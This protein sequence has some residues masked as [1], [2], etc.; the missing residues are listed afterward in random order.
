MQLANPKHSAA[1][2]LI[3][4]ASAFAQQDATRQT[5]QLRTDQ[6]LSGSISRDTVAR[7]APYPLN[8]RYQ[9][10]TPQEKA[11]LS[12]LYK[13][14]PESDEPPFPQSGMRDIVRDISD[15]AGRLELRGAMTIFVS[16]S[17]QGVAES[18]KLVKYDDLQTAKAVAYVL[19]KT[20]Y[21]PAICSGSACAME[22]PFMFKF[23]T[24]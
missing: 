12:E 7:G 22:F 21:K 24:R 13:E 1:I 8:K 16:V 4:V 18:V 14:M 15:L 3:C 23:E 19:V 20:K 2:L 9:D 17:S 5:Y 6:I 11:V 10:F